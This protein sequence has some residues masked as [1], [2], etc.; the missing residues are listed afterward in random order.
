MTEQNSAASAASTTDLNAMRVPDLQALAATF[1]IKGRLRK[2]EL[3][4]AIE[5]AQ[6]EAGAG[7]KTE[8]SAVDNTAETAS[9]AA[10]ENANADDEQASSEQHEEAR[11]ETQTDRRGDE[12]PRAR[13]TRRVSAN[14]SEDAMNAPVTE[15]AP[16]ETPAESDGET[17]MSLDDLIL[18]PARGEED[19][20]NKDDTEQGERRTRKR[21]R[22]RGRRGR[23]NGGEAHQDSNEQKEAQNSEGQQD[24]NEDESDDEQGARRNRNRRGRGQN[25]G[26]D[27]D[28]DTSND[29]SNDGDEQEARRSRRNRD[30]KRN[31]RDDDVDPEI[32]PDDVLLPIAGILDVLDNYA[33]VRTSGYLPGAND[34][35]VSLGQVKKYG[36]RKGDAIVGAIR[37]P[38]EGEQHHGRQKYNAI[39]KFDSI[40]GKTPE[41]IKERPEFDQLT[42][43]YPSERLQ[44]ETAGGHVGQRLIDLFAPIGKGSRGLIVAPP[45]SG[46]SVV[47]ERV[48]NA[49]AETSPETHLMLV[50]V[51]ERPEELTRMQRTIRGEV[52]AATFDLPAD[53]Q[54]TIAELAIERA[55]RLVELGLDVVVL[56]DSITHLCRAYNL[57]APTS[58]RILDGGVDASALYPPKRFFGAARNVE[59][60]GSLTILAT[61]MTEA[62]SRMDEVIL[63]E[64][65]GTENLE[66]RLSKEI[67]DRRIFPALDIQNSSTLM[68]ETLLTKAEVEATW[69]IRRALSGTDAGSVLESVLERLEST[70]SNAEF[71]ESVRQRPIQ[72]G[73]VTR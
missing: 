59:N 7:E 46:K 72:A 44:L 6:A 15:Q 19:E 45:K 37:Q 64:F 53:D 35:Y 1:G 38:R 56:L 70:S 42:P 58:G 24:S 8:E 11:T 21:S 62:G 16:V 10:S 69:S 51:D 48:A 43:L 61:A 54:T 5:A 33:F 22:G 23:G 57:T 65:R 60:G 68:E 30:R 66:I 28:G 39:V 32:A 71:V 18:P 17:P 55:K 14:V 40:N 4:A 9:D 12:T 3:I 31:R 52:V 20:E 67:A 27:Q 13:R 49:I 41:E 73:K 2:S 50:L 47:L 36:L 29:A 63:E 26:Q 34:V 25:G